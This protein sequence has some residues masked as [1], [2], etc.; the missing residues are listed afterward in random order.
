MTTLC[1]GNAEHFWAMTW[2]YYIMIDDCKL[3]K[4]FQRMLMLN[5][6]EPVKIVHL[7]KEKSSGVKRPVAWMVAINTTDDVLLTRETSFDV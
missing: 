5:S 1:S 7:Q 3:L 2:K 4:F 6:N